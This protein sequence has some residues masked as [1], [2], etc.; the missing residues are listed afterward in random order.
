METFHIFH[1]AAS[2][3]VE[4][5]T[6]QPVVPPLSNIAAAPAI[7]SDRSAS[8]QTDPPA[9]VATSAKDGS[10]LTPR[11]RIRAAAAQIIFAARNSREF[12]TPEE[13]ARI[14]DWSGRSVLE[15]LIGFQVAPERLHTDEGSVWE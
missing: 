3:P 5:H 7:S 4:S 11:P 8:T 12:I 2:W 10:T 6:A 15:A 9:K 1:L 13:V 14:E